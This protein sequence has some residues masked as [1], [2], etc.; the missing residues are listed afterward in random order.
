M[1]LM[2]SSGLRCWP[3]KM[4]GRQ[5]RFTFFLSC[6]LVTRTVHWIVMT[7]PVFVVARRCFSGFLRAV[8]VTTN[9]ASVCTSVAGG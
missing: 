1:C 9:L 3:V 5:T 7:N 6:S 8:K 2:Q 4:S